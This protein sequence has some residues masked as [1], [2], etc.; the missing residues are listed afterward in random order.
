M[1]TIDASTALGPNRVFGQYRIESEIGRG[2]FGTVFR[3]RDQLLERTVALK[4]L[5]AGDNGTNE[6]LLSQQA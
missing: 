4:V 3:A 2:K 1:L 6:S 5:Q